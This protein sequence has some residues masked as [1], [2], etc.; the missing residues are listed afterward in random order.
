MA[1][2]SWRPA[3]LP[4]QALPPNFLSPAHSAQESR[5]RNNAGAPP[6]AQETVLRPAKATN[7]RVAEGGRR[8]VKR[9]SRLVL[10][11]DGAAPVV[12]LTTGV[13]AG[14]KPGP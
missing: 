5:S 8:G 9:F 14:A 4:P 11:K 6:R 7:S 10:E 13:R 1:A 2:I 3:P 12:K